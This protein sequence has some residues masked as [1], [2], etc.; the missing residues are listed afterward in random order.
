MGHLS[1]VRPTNGPFSSDARNSPP[2][3]YTFATCI[4]L[5]DS[6]R[7]R[8]CMPH[9]RGTGTHAKCDR[10]SS[11]TAPVVVS[12][13]GVEVSSGS[14]KM[15]DLICPT[16]GPLPSDNRPKNA[17][18]ASSMMT[19]KCKDCGGPI[20]RPAPQAWNP[21]HYCSTCLLER[22]REQHNRSDTKMRGRRGQTGSADL[23]DPRDFVLP[24]S[25]D[26]SFD[27]KALYHLME[28]GRRGARP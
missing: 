14:P 24:G 17:P 4:L 19:T 22:E 11:T 15:T 7:E 18:S 25:E 12:G 20:D 26:G 23:A 1:D 13:S 2:S 21:P 9:L 5:D 16:N 27:P 6:E 28:R 10:T 8:L 3:L